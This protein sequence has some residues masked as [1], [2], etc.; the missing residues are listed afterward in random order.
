MVPGEIFEILAAGAFSGDNITTTA[1]NSVITN[2]NDWN[3]II[4]LLATQNYDLS[5]SAIDFNREYALFI[6]DEPRPDGKYSITVDKVIYTPTE[7]Q[8]YIKKIVTEYGH[9][10]PT[11]PFCVAKI[12]K[13]NLP[14]NF[15]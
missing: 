13:T 1:Q 14:V 3:Q 11:Q 9:H 12:S 4:A 8:V 15:Y 10:M 2:Q 7:V 5:S 6:R